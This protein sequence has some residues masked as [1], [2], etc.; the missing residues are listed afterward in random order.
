[1]GRCSSSGTTRPRR[2]VRSTRLTPPSCES[3]CPTCSIDWRSA[4]SG[5]GMPGVA[6]SAVGPPVAQPARPTNPIK[7]SISRLFI[8][9]MRDLR[10]YA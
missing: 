5:L 9:A 7:A 6:I 4:I 10:S 1:M 3:C 2:A 8:L